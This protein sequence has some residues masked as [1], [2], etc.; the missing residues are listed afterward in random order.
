ML[1]APDDHA[2]T[3]CIKIEVEPSVFLKSLNGK[4]QGYANRTPIGKVSYD[5]NFRNVEK[6]RIKGTS[7][8]NGQAIHTWVFT[9]EAEGRHFLDFHS[10]FGDSWAKGLCI[11]QVDEKKGYLFSNGN[12]SH[13]KLWFNPIVKDEIKIE[14]FLGNKP[15]VSITVLKTES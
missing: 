4:W 12:P 1:G 8:T 10:T 2:C 9:S 14:I 3:E 5:L 15:H 11:T 7:F 13:L 6:K